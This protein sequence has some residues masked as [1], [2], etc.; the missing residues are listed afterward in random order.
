MDVRWVT[1]TGAEQRDPDQLEDRLARDDGFLWVDLPLGDPS[2]ERG[3]D[4]R[5]QAPPAGQGRGKV[6]IVGLTCGDSDRRP[7]SASAGGF[8]ALTCSRGVLL[9]PRSERPGGASADVAMGL[10][11]VPQP[12]HSDICPGHILV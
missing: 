6:R 1:A 11:A 12:P 5:A 9:L 3:A 4:R 7:R 2:T 8:V 10:G